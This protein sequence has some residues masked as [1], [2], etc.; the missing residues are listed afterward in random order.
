M[1]DGSIINAGYYQ[2]A[3]LIYAV[4]ALGLLLVFWR[5]VR[6]FHSADI[7]WYLM[8]V[9]ASGLVVPRW[10]Q[11]EFAYSAPAILVGAFDF[12]DGLDKG[13]PAAI[14]RASES[15]WPIAA[16]IG[17]ATLALVIRRLFFR[18]KPV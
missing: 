8:S 10:G 15:L 5:I 2:L 7:R 11:G 1:T 9:L 16:L 18:K 6:R 17:I 3:W 12:L 14:D 4:A 13:L